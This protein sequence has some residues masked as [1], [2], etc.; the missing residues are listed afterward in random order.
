[1]ASPAGRERRS[2]ASYTEADLYGYI[3][4]GAGVVL[5]FGFE[6]L[7][8]QK[9]TKG[10]ATFTWISTE[11]AIRSRHRHLPDEVRERGAPTRVRRAAHGESSPTPVPAGPVLRDYQQRLGPGVAGTELVAFGGAVASKM[12]PTSRCRSC[13]GSRRPGRWTP[14]CVFCAGRTECRRSTPGRGRHPAARWEADGGGSRLQG[15]LGRLHADRSQL[16]DRSGRHEGIRLPDQEPGQLPEAHREGRITT[17]VLGL[18]EEVRR[19]RRQRRHHRHQSESRHE[20]A[21]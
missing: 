9:Y 4:G 19:G 21:K 12:P 11:C 8:Q 18:P 17:G 13:R 10:T 16:S 15:R 7:T 14:H 5:E 1:M 20:A 3:D 6:Q 2:N